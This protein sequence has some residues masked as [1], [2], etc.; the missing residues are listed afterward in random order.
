MIPERFHRH[1]TLMPVEKL[2]E[3][4]INIIG[5]G[6][7]GSFTC[8]SL[9][10][11]GAKR[12]QIWDGD[13]IDEVN[14]ANQF[15][16]GKDV[17]EYKVDA[18]SAVIQDFEDTPIRVHPENFSTANTDINGIVISALDSM[19]PRKMVWDTVKNNKD[20][21]DLFIDP[22]MGAKVFRIYVINPKD[23]KA[24]KSYE[25][26]LY[27]DD[28]A[29]QERCTEKTIIYNV[30]GIASWISRAVER[31]LSKGISVGYEDIVDYETYIHM[32]TEYA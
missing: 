16:R 26:S 18:L 3:T 8:L 11:M 19:A 12:M 4:P 30:L 32:H 1:W 27:T 14:R 5:V 9:I 13:L 31:H 29:T 7:V 23:D 28:E 10:K 21:V 22:R 17:G 24:I 25:E 15:V 2:M 6:S 20:K